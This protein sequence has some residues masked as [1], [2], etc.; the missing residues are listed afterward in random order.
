MLHLVEA[1][2]AT[3]PPVTALESRRRRLDRIGDWGLRAVT[4][5]AAFGAVALIGLVIYKVVDA[6]RPSI[7]TFGI[8]FLWHR[9]WDAVTNNFGALDFI[10][11][12]LYTTTFAVL[13]AA[14]V[15]IAIGLY[16]SELAPKS[17]RGVI[18]TLVE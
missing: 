8:S 12:T 15:S 2:S 6:A 11:A 9:T 17:V 1:S 13:F 5:V 16:L 7:S 3:T 10:F 18:G 14:P 4:A